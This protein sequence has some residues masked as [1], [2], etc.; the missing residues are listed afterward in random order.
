MAICIAAVPQTINY[1]GY[2]AD[3]G[4]TPVNGTVQ[5]Q[6]K[7]YS[8]ESAT[9]SPL[10]TETHQSVQVNQGSYSVVLGN[11][12]PTPVPIDLP[13]DVQYYLGVKVGS[14]AEMTPRLPLT[15][16]GYAFHATQ[17][18]GLSS[19][20]TL[21]ATNAIVSTVPTGVA[22]LAV[23]STTLVPNLNAD[24]VGGK[25]ASDLVAKAGDTMT[26]NLTVPSATLNG[27]LTLP[28]TSATAGIIMQGGN[29]LIHSYGNL[30]FFAGR[31]SGNL[32]MTGFGNTASGYLTL[33]PNTTGYFNTAGGAFALRRNTTG[34]GNTAYG[35]NTLTANDAGSNN[36]ASG[37]Q[38]L[39]DN[40]TG[41]YNTA[42][43]ESAL[44]MNS[45]GS[46]NTASGSAALLSTTTGSYN[47]ASGYRALYSNTTGNYNT[48][49]GYGADVYTG[50]LTNATAI[51]A[52]AVVDA[53]NTVR[54]GDTNVQSIRAHVSGIT[55]DSDL[56]EKKDIQDIGYGLSFIK[57]LRPVQYR[58]KEGNNR[59]DFGFIAQD[60]ET[61]LGID[62]N[63]LGIGG[64]E[65]RMLSLRYTDFIAPM[66]KAMQEQQVIIDDLKAR[67]EKL[68]ALLA[69]QP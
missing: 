40:L 41:N 42:T 59:I 25:H 69:A 63:I 20:A 35:A 50:S 28:T 21:T 62:Y 58:L 33:Y 36:T 64:T 3:S 46:A 37:I 68:E 1:Q 27:I 57:T 14:D 53:S 54:I 18:D 15:S 61:L 13:F 10:W 19:S 43:G 45:A 9:A 23:A 34:I 31:D 5:M 16:M 8:S 6:F 66:V 2:L 48:A 11:G 12:S 7:L 67:I 47:T 55:A 4:G 22:P 44:A 56:R 38:A 26:G 17:A 49:V 52:N 29:T 24:M 51:G 60:I 65:E 39:S 32:T 30:N